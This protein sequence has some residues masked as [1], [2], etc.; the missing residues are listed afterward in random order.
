[1]KSF[2][3]LAVFTA[4]ALAVCFAQ[5]QT[6]PG[7]APATLSNVNFYGNLTG[8]TGG[9]NGSGM[10]NLLFSSNG[11]DYSIGPNGELTNPVAFT[12]TK[13]GAN[14][15][16]I[17]EPQAGSATPLTVSL[18]FT[19]AVAGT[20]LA[21]YGAGKTQSGTF[22][23]ISIP[24]AAPL[25]NMS[26]RVIVR[27]G[28]MAIPGFVIAGS[29][30]RRVL[31]RAVGPGLTQFGLTS[32]LPNP[33]ISLWRGSSQIGANDDWGSDSTLAG[34]FSQ[35]G[36]FGLAVGSKD[37]AMVTSL[38]PG[39]YTAMVKGGTTTEQGEVLVELYLV[40]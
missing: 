38:Q 10:V 14:T 20:F 24:G 2:R 18:T 26:N 19:S 40:D 15:A 37:A 3:F 21:D 28:E 5:A 17:V 8:S 25:I 32:V 6:N 11:L 16:T 39:A 23:L 30:P 29:A 36:A 22:S 27:A 7:F 9:A 4:M 33:T 34:V 1:M 35:V 31:I 12:Y 13:T